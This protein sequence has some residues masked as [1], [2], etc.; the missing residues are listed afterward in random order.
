MTHD[1]RPRPH[2]TAPQPTSRRSVRTER[3]RGA[4]A[5]AQLIS[6]AVIASY[7]H[8]ISQRHSDGASASGSG[9]GLPRT[10]P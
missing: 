10:H 9:R 4:R 1:N 7:I 5:S 8:D 3:R 2:T 6:D